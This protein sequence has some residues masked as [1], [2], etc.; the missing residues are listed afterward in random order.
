MDYTGAVPQR[1]KG[2]CVPVTEGI[3]YFDHAKNPSHPAHWH[4]REDG[5]MGTSLCRH[6]AIVIKKEKPL[7]VR[8]LMHA[9][10][11]AVNPAITDRIAALFDARPS[12]EIAK[13]KRRH[14]HFEVRRAG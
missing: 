4:V 14:R 7:R 10:R 12:F 6:E 11:G 13:A 3:T 1:V 2:K 8:Y 9:H 5:W